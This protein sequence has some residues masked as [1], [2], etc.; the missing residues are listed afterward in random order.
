MQ[1]TKGRKPECTGQL[2]QA[3]E[4]GAVGASCYKSTSFLCAMM[5]TTRCCFLFVDNLGHLT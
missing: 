5:L 1:Q 4:L 3:N 2:L